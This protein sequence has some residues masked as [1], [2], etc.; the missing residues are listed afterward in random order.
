MSLDCPGQLMVVVLEQAVERNLIVADDGWG[1]RLRDAWMRESVARL[2]RVITKV[3][4]V[5]ATKLLRDQAQEF[6]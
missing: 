1:C 4:F 2:T 3:G 5:R 6:R